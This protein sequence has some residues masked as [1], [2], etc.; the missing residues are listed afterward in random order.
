E[1][2]SPRRTEE[3]LL[4]AA[5]QTEGLKL[6]IM[7]AVAPERVGTNTATQGTVSSAC[8]TTAAIASAAVAGF[9]SSLVPLAAPRSG[10]LDSAVAAIFASI[11]RVSRGFCPRGD[12][13]KSITQA[14]P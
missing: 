13:P 14:V 4:T 11:P 2:I 5:I 10:R 3:S 1:N 9:G 8:S 12:S 6:E 7:R